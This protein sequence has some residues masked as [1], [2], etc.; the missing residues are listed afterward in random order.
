M[1]TSGVSDLAGS[2]LAGRYRLVAPIGTGASGRVYSAWDVRLRRRVAVKVLHAALAEDA[3]FLRRFGAEAQLAASLQHPNIV[4]VFDWGGDETPF[5]VLELLEGGSL[6]AMLDQGMRFSPSQA[7]ALGRQVA[8]ALH[9]AHVRGLVHRDVKPANLLFDGHGLV[10]VAD[11]GL[12]RALAEASWTEPA[13]AVL[14]TARY[15]A[16]EQVRGVALDGRSDLYSLA[17]VLVEAVTGTVPFA[18]ETSLGTLLSRVDRPLQA[19]PE[20]GPLG[21]VLERAARP[22]PAERFP[23]AS[24]FAAALSDVA[25]QLPPPEPLPLAGAGAAEDSTSDPTTLRPAPAPVPTPDLHPAAPTP[26]EAQSGRGRRLVPLVVLALVVLGASAA[27]FAVTRATGPR[28]RVPNLVGRT[29]AEARAGATEAGLRVR[30][31][32]AT[33]DDPP[34]TV[35]RQDPDPGKLFGRGGRIRLVVSSGPAPIPV[36]GVEGQP[37]EQARSVLDAAGFDVAVSRV[38]DEVVDEGNVV[39]QDPRP[40]QRLAPGGVVQLR[41]SDGPRPVVV[42]SVVG[43]TY[44]EAVAILKGKGFTVTRADDYS[45]SVDPG[46]V[47][48]QDPVAG[49]E[50][51][52]GAKVTVTVSRGPDLVVVPDVRGLP[53]EVAVVELERAGLEADVVS[54][55][56]F[57]AVKRQ[58]PP[59]GTKVRRGETVTLFL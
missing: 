59:S 58:D 3:G 2:V 28:V 47:I 43:K 51:S 53:V 33:A 50:A 45:D 35:T 4:T 5:L 37:E 49:E 22:E 17:L 38:F 32:R 26:A 48:R 23:D 41:V 8:G 44:D 14:G 36:P 57:R 54:Y 15:A 56:P 34:G 19:P 12:A 9:H 18:A 7:A 21:P 1:R 42:P 11:F 31:S 27:A 46:D 10:R 55:R 16:P 24:A 20:L 13:G 39:S 52:R 40:G 25:Q 6:R 30:V 29:E